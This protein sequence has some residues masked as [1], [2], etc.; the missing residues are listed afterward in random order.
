[1]AS[2]PRTH[3]ES[4]GL[5]LHLCAFTLLYEGFSLML[6]NADTEYTICLTIHRCIFLLQI[7]P[8]FLRIKMLRIDKSKEHIYFAYVTLHA[9][10]PGVCCIHLCSADR[11]DRTNSMSQVKSWDHMTIRMISAMC[12]FLRP[13]KF[14][15]SVFYFFIYFLVQTNRRKVRFSRAFL[16][17][18][19]FKGH[20]TYKVKL[21][22]IW[23]VSS[24]SLIL[25]FRTQRSVLLS[26]QQ[27]SLV[28]RRSLS[29]SSSLVESSSLLN[30]S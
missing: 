12:G 16:L 25:W 24:S 28:T 22:V 17:Q 2:F 13:H 27:R 5:F 20:L 15:L 6:K 29:S 11:T 14:L 7:S 23:Y 8:Y 30:C 18:Q 1:M 26:T 19:W 21:R 4:H 10:V 3:F 9:R